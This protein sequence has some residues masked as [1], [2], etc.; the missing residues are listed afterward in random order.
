MERN[1]AGMILDAFT[2]EHVTVTTDVRSEEG[3]PLEFM[4][5]RED[6]SEEDGWLFG[7]F[8]YGGDRVII[9]VAH[10]VAVQ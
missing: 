4:L 8:L 1:L 10:I 7:R 3:D 6:V 2:T 9:A 5:V